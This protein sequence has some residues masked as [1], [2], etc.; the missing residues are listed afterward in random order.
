MLTVLGERSIFRNLRK[1]HRKLKPSNMVLIFT[2]TL[3]S[4]ASFVPASEM[5]PSFRPG[6]TFNLLPPFY[7]ILT[8]DVF[9]TAFGELSEKELEYYVKLFSQGRPLWAALYLLQPDITLENIVALVQFAQQKLV[10]NR[11][12]L[13]TTT[14]AYIAVL[15]VRCGIQGVLDHSL[16]SKLMS[17]YMG[18][19]IYLDDDR[20]RMAVVY[21]AEPI[22][23]EAACHCIHGTTLDSYPPDSKLNTL[24]SEFIGTCINGLVSAGEVGEVIARCILSF[25]YDFAQLSSFKLKK[26]LIRNDESFADKI[27]NKLLFSKPLPITDF[28]DSLVSAEYAK[29]Y[30]DLFNTE[31]YALPNEFLHGTV[32]FTSWEY[33]DTIEGENL[34]QTFLRSCYEKRVAVAFPWNQKGADFLIPVRLLNGYSFLLVQVKNRSRLGR[35]RFL[36]GGNNVTPKHC[37]GDGKGFRWNWPY[38][39]IYMEIGNKNIF[40]M[41]EFKRGALPRSPKDFSQKYPNHMLLVGFGSF[42]ALLQGGL[43]STFKTFHKRHVQYFNNDERI[44]LLKRMHPLSFAF[45]KSNNMENLDEEDKGREQSSSQSDEIRPI[46]MAPTVDTIVPSGVPDT[47]TTEMNVDEQTCVLA[48]MPKVSNKASSLSGKRRRSDK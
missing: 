37:F 12:C 4:L 47:A 39:S 13:P 3:S 28:L 6:Q 17:S 10:M 20:I 29:K 38:M 42:A 44:D 40:E 2:D 48:T 15:S 34:D 26:K 31:L 24:L 14:E 7:E 35:R 32:S 8:F 41:K 1:A 9:K 23:G 5:D 46:P 33:L 16:A 18:T 19:G 21:P 25:S 22:L 45:S 30:K 11:S 27:E 36:Y 43:T